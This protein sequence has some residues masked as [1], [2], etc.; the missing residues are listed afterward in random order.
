MQRPSPILFA[1]ATATLMLGRPAALPAAD[2]DS[3]ALART[4]RRPDPISSI[5]EGSA[6]LDSQDVR[7]LEVPESHPIGVFGNV[8]TSEPEDRLEARRLVFGAAQSAQGIGRPNDIFGVMSALDRTR[9]R[10]E[11]I[12]HAGE[13]EEWTLMGF[14]SI[15]IAPALQLQPSLGWS[16]EMDSGTTVFHGLVGLKLKF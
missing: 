2:L 16:G 7:W 9:D 10:R 1:V 8:L 11:L 13:I 12:P 14:Y 6:V 3:D 4:L 5:T 15:Q